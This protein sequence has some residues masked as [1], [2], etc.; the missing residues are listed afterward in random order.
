MSSAVIDS[1]AS[2]KLFDAGLEIAE[3]TFDAF[4]EEGVLREIPIFQTLGALYRSGLE[5][6]QQ[7]FFRKI[8]G[9][10]NKLSDIPYDERKRFIEENNSNEF[11]ETLLLLIDRADS[12][13]KPKILGNLM[14]NH[15]LDE[16]SYEDTERLA[17]IVDRVYISDLDYLI[18]FTP[19]VQE[20]P[21]IAASLFSVG[22]L[23]NS[24]IDGG[25]FADTHSPGGIIYAMSRYGKML[26]E[27]GLDC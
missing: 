17:F 15:I 1:I 18:N 3:V 13:Q 16:L 10:I 11:G 14:R 8:V 6:R 19:G 9:F 27:Y 21:D 20:N 2:E 23:T 22:L 12:M 7:L 24:G 4:L 26:L 25:S 5:I